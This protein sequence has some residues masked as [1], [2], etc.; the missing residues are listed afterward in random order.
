ML[1]LIAVAGQRIRVAID[2]RRHE[3]SGDDVFEKVEPEDRELGQHLSFAGNAVRQDHIEGGNSI[4][5]NNQK[6]LADSVD[7]A[8]LA[9]GHPFAAGEVGGKQYRGVVCHL[10]EAFLGMPRGYFKLLMISS[11][12]R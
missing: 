12:R 2:I 9:P 11:L 8:N 1:E 7:I 5:S 10:R 4:G 3:V 6:L